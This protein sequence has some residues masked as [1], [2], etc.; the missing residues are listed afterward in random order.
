M[1]KYIIIH[2]SAT[3]GRYETGINIIKNQ[4]KK[5]GKNSNSNA[6]HYMI[7]NDGRIIP[8]KSE[9]VVVGHCGY[10]GY[11]YSTEPCN[12]NSLGICFLG[13]FEKNE[14]PQKQLEAGLALIKGLVKKY[15]IKKIYGHRDVTNTDCPGKFLY[16]KIPYIE[17]EVFMSD[18]KNELLNWAVQKGIIKN[19]ELHQNLDIPFTKAEMLAILKNILERLK[20][21]IG[22]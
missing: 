18:W 8:W 21:D 20:I 15:N 14:V 6:Y 4:E 22:G 1:W 2:H 7:T 17:K 3:D 10:D 9:N 19:P 5:Y 16:T 11:S 13:N 12:F